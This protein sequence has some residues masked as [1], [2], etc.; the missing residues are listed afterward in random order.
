V[1]L[2]EGCGEG[3]AAQKKAPAEHAAHVAGLVPQ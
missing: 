1:G 3:A 2:G